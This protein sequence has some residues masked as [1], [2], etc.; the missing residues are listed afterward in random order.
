MSR[1]G[2]VCPFVH[3]GLGHSHIPAF[4]AVAFEMSPEATYPTA[5]LQG[6]CSDSRPSPG[7]VGAL[8]LWTPAASRGPQGPFSTSASPEELGRGGRR[9]LKG[10]FSPQE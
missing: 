7:A 10:L 1:G 3:S 9:E 2:S 8:A 6:A 4:L 5:C